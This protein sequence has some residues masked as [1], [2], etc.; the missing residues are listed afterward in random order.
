MMGLTKSQPVSRDALAHPS[1]FLSDTFQSMLTESISAILASQSSH[2]STLHSA[3]RMF[4]AEPILE[5]TPPSL[6]S[7]SLYTSILPNKPSPAHG[8]AFIRSVSPLPQT[9][10][11]SVRRS[12]SPVQSADDWMSFSRRRFRVPSD[13]AVSSDSAAERSQMGNADLTKHDDDVIQSSPP[14]SDENKAQ[15]EKKK[16]SRS[17]RFLENLKPQM[18][19]R[20]VLPAS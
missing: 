8:P 15:T 10:L 16:P 17:K 19:G 1:A 20:C 7:Q 6:S 3:P 11:R 12:D 9:G 2:H 14:P 18:E 4:S 13:S 5:E